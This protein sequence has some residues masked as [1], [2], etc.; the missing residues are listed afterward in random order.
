MRYLYQS[1][2]HLQEGIHSPR[3]L[4]DESSWNDVLLLPENL[5][6][7]HQSQLNATTEANQRVDKGKERSYDNNESPLTS[8]RMLNVGYGTPFR[9][10]SQFFD[11]P[12]R[13]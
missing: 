3:R 10:S 6:E 9:S 7:L 13:Q 4:T 2:P 1:V 11:K 12:D 8:P 5:A